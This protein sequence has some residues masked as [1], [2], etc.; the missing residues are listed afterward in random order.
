[1]IDIISYLQTL[2]F[3]GLIVPNELS[4]LSDQTVIPLF[5]FLR[6]FR[7]GYQQTI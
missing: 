4:I 5:F 3:H 7:S 1:M 2:S 6:Q